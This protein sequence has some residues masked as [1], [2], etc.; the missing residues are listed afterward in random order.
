MELITFVVADGST[1][2]SFNIKPTNIK[3]CT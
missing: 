1:Y 2:V 3:I